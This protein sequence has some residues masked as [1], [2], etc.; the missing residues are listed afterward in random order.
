MACE[1]GPHTYKI[2]IEGI[3]ANYML[4]PH[5][6]AFIETGSNSP[7]VMMTINHVSEAQK[8]DFQ[9]AMGGT[10]KDDGRSGI[11]VYMRWSD[12]LEMGDSV[13]VTVCQRGAEN[14]GE[15]EPLPEDGFDPKKPTKIFEEGPIKS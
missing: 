3:T 15:P 6:R 11:F 7:T 5:F 13:T 10:R 12:T 8:V 9:N 1:F 2:V 14:Y 4:Y